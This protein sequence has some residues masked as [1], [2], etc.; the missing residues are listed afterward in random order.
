M[1]VNETRP[2]AKCHC[3]M[4]RSSVK[5]TACLILS[6]ILKPCLVFQRAW[7]PTNP[8]ISIFKEVFTWE[9]SHRCQ[10]HT[11]M[12]TL[13]R[14]AFTWFMLLEEMGLI[15]PHRRLTP[16]SIEENYACATRSSLPRDRFHI[17]TSGCCSSFTWY[18]CETS[19]R[20]EMFS[21]RNSNRSELAPV[22][23]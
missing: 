11:G 20:N 18:H 4:T 9:N 10:F 8:F 3:H 23:L 16:C 15:S 17:E 12:T 13:F 21:P 2:T 14:I 1:E 5:H 19:Y 22:W 6:V 7:S